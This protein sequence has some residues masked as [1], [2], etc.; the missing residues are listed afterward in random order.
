M[1]V[2]VIRIEDRLRG[3]P[4][5]THVRVAFVNSSYRDNSFEQGDNPG[6]WAGE[7]SLRIGME[8]CFFLQRHPDADFQMTIRQGYPLEKR[9]LRYGAQIELVRKACHAFEQ[10][11]EALQA[12]EASDRQL[13]ACVLIARHGQL[14]ANGGDGKE[15]KGSDLS[16]AES[17]L[18]LKNLAEMKWNDTANNNEYIL[19][20][21]GA[22]NNLYPINWQAPQVGEKDDAGA[23]Y[24]KAISNWVEKSQETF[25]IKR[26]IIKGA[27]Q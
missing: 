3:T 22:L 18:V 23:V 21:N 1:A 4:G 25:R 10:P 11:L 20:K 8:G 12:K 16:S 15:I 2:A 5:V 27:S 17:K 14:T 19:T 13:A 6:H 26:G 7:Q 9:E 24:D